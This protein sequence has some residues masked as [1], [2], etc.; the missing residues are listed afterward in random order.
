[1]TSS[2]LHLGLSSPIWLW[3]LKD[4]I[5]WL[6]LNECWKDAPHPP[7][8]TMGPSVLKLKC[9]LHHM[10]DD[11]ASK[12]G[13][14]IFQKQVRC[15]VYHLTSRV[16][17]ICFADI[18]RN[19]I[20]NGIQ[21]D[22]NE[23]K[24][25]LNHIK[26]SNSIKAK[27]INEDKKDGFLFRKKSLQVQMLNSARTIG[28][29]FFLMINHASKFLKLLMHALYLFLEPVVSCVNIVPPKVNTCI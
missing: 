24:I 4:V 29:I 8:L 25:L 27:F 23:M 22:S 3:L 5:T 13:G 18:S 15:I 20:P 1:M 26:Y 11:G 9:A 21:W 14:L 16:L 6:L 19:K 7:R 28:D 10:S 12:R 2:Y 17:H